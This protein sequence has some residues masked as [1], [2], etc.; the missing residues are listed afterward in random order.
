MIQPEELEL[1]DQDERCLC[2]HAQVIH[3]EDEAWGGCH[4]EGCDCDGFELN[5]HPWPRKRV[6]PCVPPTCSAIQ[7]QYSTLLAQTLEQ[8]RE[9]IVQ[10]VYGKP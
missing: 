10:E 4:C 1:L 6:D 9:K 8:W 5:C 3:W 7:R 2:G